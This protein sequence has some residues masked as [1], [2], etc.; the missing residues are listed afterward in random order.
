VAPPTSNY[1]GSVPV[2]SSAVPEKPNTSNNRKSSKII[3][4]TLEPNDIRWQI[5]NIFTH[6]YN[7]CDRQGLLYHLTTYCTPD[8]SCVYKYI[9]NQSPYGPMYIEL[10]GIE[11]VINYW[12]LVFC[13]IPDSV[14]ENHATK[15]RML[16]NGKAA[17]VTKYMFTGTKLCDIVTQDRKE[18]WISSSVPNHTRASEEKYKELPV[19]KP[20]EVLMSEILPVSLPLTIIGTVTYYTNPDTKIYKIEYVHAMRT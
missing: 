6:A 8:V 17:I 15:I 1:V 4:V 12:D 11:A 5:S 16:P 10:F 3:P 7:T 18:V 14:F 13:A 19:V 9:G 2:I 20:E